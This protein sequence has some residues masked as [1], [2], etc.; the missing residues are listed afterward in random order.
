MAGFTFPPEIQRVMLDLQIDQMERDRKRVLADPVAHKLTLYFPEGS[1]GPNWRYV[2]VEKAGFPQ[3]R[4]CYST[5]RNLAG[6]FLG[7]RETINRD[8]SGKRDQWVA[9]K[10][11]E[12]VRQKAHQRVEAHNRRVKPKPPKPP[13]E[14][15]R[16]SYW[17]SEHL[18]DGRTRGL[19]RVV[20]KGGPDR[21]LEIA[22]ER[23]P[24]ATAELRT[25]RLGRD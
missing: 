12:T 17:V 9:S 23:W 15:R 16:L 2:K 13:V 24:H 1:R 11:R 3:V 7:W 6:Y 19:G 18:G 10:R 25:F 5:S 21:A 4:Y 20:T 8:G 14:E 22:R